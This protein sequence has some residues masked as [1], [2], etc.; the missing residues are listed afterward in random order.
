MFYKT[1]RGCK[2]VPVEPFVIMSGHDHN[3]GFTRPDTDAL[4]FNR[5]GLEMNVTRGYSRYIAQSSDLVVIHNFTGQ[6]ITKVDPA[7][8]R[9]SIAADNPPFA[10]MNDRMFSNAGSLT[11]DTKQ[12]LDHQ[13]QINAN[14]NVRDHVVVIKFT[15]IAAGTVEALRSRTEGLALSDNVKRTI[16]S[17]L[18]QNVHKGNTFSYVYEFML[19]Y[20][21]H[22]SEFD[23]VHTVIEP[24]T[25]SCL[26]RLSF[27]NAYGHP[28][29]MRKGLIDVSPLEDPYDPNQPLYL[30]FF[31][32][33]HNHEFDDRFININGR[34]YL[35]PQFQ[36]TTRKE[37]FYISSY[38]IAENARGMTYE[39]GFI[40][41]MEMTETNG[42]YKTAE[43]ARTRKSYE[44]AAKYLDEVIDISKTIKNLKVETSKD[45]NSHTKATFD[46]LLQLSERTFTD[47]RAYVQKKY[48]EHAA[49]V[50]QTT[51][52]IEKL[53]DELRDN[54]RAHETAMQSRKEVLETIRLVPPL[55][56]CI[57]AF[58]AFKKKN[59]Q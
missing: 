17:C 12:K 27:E 6:D 53:Q 3:T 10:A 43:L 49:Y 28:L 50:A 15:N 56:G 26:T 16:L 32:V 57:A 41:L 47:A 21:I 40:P 2:V 24:Q 20:L 30:N 1:R 9:T 42:F 51:S 46:K 31:I 11:D 44:Q 37:G 39:D 36:D 7:G 38:H 45:V 25:Q 8:I 54:K 58:M 5:V 14:T 19:V 52:V 48:S 13:C 33:Y 59:Q 34:V 35:V 18:P 4:L 29:D 55:L 23:T 22:K